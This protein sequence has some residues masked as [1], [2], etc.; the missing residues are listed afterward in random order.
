MKS[1]IS[2]EA[3]NCR[4]REWDA[5]VQ[6]CRKRPNDTVEHAIIPGPYGT[7]A[8]GTRFILQA[9]DEAIQ[10]RDSRAKGETAE[11]SIRNS[12]KVAQ[13]NFEKQLKA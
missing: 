11:Q 6:K 1:R 2:Q 3:R 10:N 4:I 9:M 12:V 5:M 13:Q 7:G 8:Y